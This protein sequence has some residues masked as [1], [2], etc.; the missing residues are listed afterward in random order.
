MLTCRFKDCN[1]KTVWCLILCQEHFKLKTN[2]ESNNI[3]GWCGKTPIENKST[4]I[5][6]ICVDR[7]ITQKPHEIIVFKYQFNLKTT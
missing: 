1:S 5:C 2:R 3:C 4:N 7:Y 6:N